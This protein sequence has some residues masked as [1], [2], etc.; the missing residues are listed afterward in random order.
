MVFQLDFKSPY[1]N[2]RMRLGNALLLFDLYSVFL[3]SDHLL[4]QKGE[5]FLSYFGL[6]NPLFTF[7][8]R[9]F[10]VLKLLNY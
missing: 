10:S 3:H 6:K 8:D 1:H 7:S 4:V 9:D 5:A 2:I